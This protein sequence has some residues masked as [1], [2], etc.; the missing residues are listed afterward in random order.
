MTDIRYQ[1]TLYP[2]NSLSP[3]GFRILISLMG[4]LFFIVGLTFLSMGA[5]PVS[6]LLGLDLLLIYWAFQHNFRENRLRELVVVDDE[7][8]K[9]KR[10]TPAG[11]EQEWSFASYWARIERE[12]D[13]HQ[14]CTAL[15]LSTHGEGIRFATFLLP[16]EREELADEISRHLGHRQPV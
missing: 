7:T 4:G 8:I 9:L 5:W 16:E 10:V 1:A 15:R 3:R 14:A 12:H 11:G 6:G 13:Q 2:N